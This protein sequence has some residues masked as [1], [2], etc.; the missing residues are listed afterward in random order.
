M[1]E[2][3]TAKEA[4]EPDYDGLLRANLERVFNERDPEKRAAAMDELFVA[5]PIMFEPGGVVHGRAAIAEV[6]GALLEQF[7]PDFRFVPTDQ[8]VG[9]HGLGVLR[10]RGG[11]EGGGTVVV[12]GSDVAEV[13]AGRIARLWV[14]LD[15][16][17][18]PVELLTFSLA[19]LVGP[20]LE[21]PPPEGLIIV[22]L[23]PTEPAWTMTAKRSA[24]RSKPLCGDPS[25]SRQLSAACARHQRPDEASHC[26]TGSSIGTVM[27]LAHSGVPT[28]S[29]WTRRSLSASKSR[30][31]T[32]SPDTTSMRPVWPIEK[33]RALVV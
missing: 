32:F 11:P 27:S 30:A 18:R 13:A 19:L 2:T 10:W 21:C 25:G 9:H 26:R 4:A 33:V 7:G 6:A 22:P 3:P 1:P 29:A 20:V 5:E 17:L 28:A 24:N 16:T 15:S 14:L 31:Q 12:T 8:A 23:R